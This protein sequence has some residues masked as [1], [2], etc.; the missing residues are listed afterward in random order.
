MVVDPKA[1]VLSTVSI[2][3]MGSGFLDLGNNS[4][5][6]QLDLFL[7]RT[8]EPCDQTGQIIGL[9]GICS[10]ISFITDVVGS[11]LHL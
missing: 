10:Q 2:A 9:V 6:G 3:T 4:P 5:M 8:A 7:R 1:G 11:W